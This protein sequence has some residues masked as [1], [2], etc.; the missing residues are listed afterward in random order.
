MVFMAGDNQS[1]DGLRD[2]TEIKEVGA[3]R[4]VN[5]V[6][7]LDRRAGRRAT[8][9]VIR[10]G[11]TLAADAAFVMD[12]PSTGDPNPL[13]DFTT[14]AIEGFRA[15][16]YLLV[17]WNHGPGRDYSDVCTS[18][19]HG[20]IRHLAQG[21]IQRAIY[22]RP[23]CKTLNRAR[24]DA[25]ARAMLAD[26]DAKDFLDIKEVT[27]TMAQF[28]QLSR[29]RLDILGSDACLASMAELGFELRQNVRFTVGS[30]QTG[31]GQSWPY[32]AI[33]SELI[34]HP[35]MSARDLSSLIVN[36]CLASSDCAGG[37]F[38]QAACDLDLAD[39]LAHAVA[40]LAGVMEAKLGDPHVRL[41]ITQA[42]DA[43]QTY[44]VPDNVDLVDFSL[45]LRSLVSGTLANRCADVID[46]VTSGGYVVTQRSRGSSLS[47]SHGA[48]IYFPVAAVNPLYEGLGFSRMTGWGT[49]LKAY[50]TQVRTN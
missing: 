48:A 17:L 47:N 18:R 38:S 16:K 31:P 13:A 23:V 39:A 50:L 8:R 5:I 9:Y 4:E 11:G 29:R 43:A 20:S 25:K 42:R 19:Q 28:E 3:S 14:W 30:E 26:G 46:V 44:D 7:H 12:R 10:S 21:L 33:L 1:P 27:T 41:Q 49:F 35:D 6:V 45:K 15:E 2:L 22:W 40:E 24:T 37:E 32:K 34:A 36:C